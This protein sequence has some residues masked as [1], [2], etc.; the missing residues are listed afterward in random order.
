MTWRSWSIVFLAVAFQLTFFAPNA[1]AG[2]GACSAPLTNQRTTEILIRDFKCFSP[3]VA[4]IDVGDRITWVNRTF[5]DH[6][7]ASANVQ[8]GSDIMGRGGSVTFLFEE[9]GTF[10]YVCQLHTGMVGTVVVGEGVGDQTVGHERALARV[11]SFDPGIDQ[12]ESEK[13]N[14]AEGRDKSENDA[15][16]AP[17]QSESSDS[18]SLA[19]RGPKST[20]PVEW[21]LVVLAAVLIP[22]TALVIGLLRR[23]YRPRIHPD[24]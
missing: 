2:G 21:F 3:T 17:G 22:A 19:S 18:R 5:E 14:N 11:I 10:P 1:R 12:K 16:P 7:V 23:R 4:R 20:L 6:N 13:S 15:A 8:W 24:S 9:E